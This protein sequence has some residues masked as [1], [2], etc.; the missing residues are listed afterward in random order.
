[1]LNSLIPMENVTK[2]NGFVHAVYEESPYGIIVFN[3]KMVIVDWNPAVEQLIGL[4]KEDC[5][6][7]EIFKV[8]SNHDSQMLQMK[9][10]GIKGTMVVAEP[11]SGYFMNGAL[12]GLKISI[13]VDKSGAV[14]GGTLI[15]TGPHPLL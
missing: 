1:M 6:G 11:L 12:S 9:A 10:N 15:L 2:M 14:N 3:S 7:R 5:I 4:S 13:I 8:F